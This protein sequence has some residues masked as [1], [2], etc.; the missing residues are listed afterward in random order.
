MDLV[1]GATP[2]NGNGIE[3]AILDTGI[4]LRHEVF[5]SKGERQ[6]EGHNFVSNDPPDSWY[7][8]PELHGTAVA[9]IAAGNQYSSRNGPCLGGIAPSAKLYICRIFSCRKTKREWKISALNHLID[10]K[11]NSKNR[12]DVVVMSFGKQ[13]KENEV[14]KKLKQLADLGVV[15]V[16]AGGNSGPRPDDAFFPSSNNH[17]I[18]VGALDR[19]GHKTN[20]SAT[21][22]R[23]YAPG[24]SIYVPSVVR[25]STTDVCP[26]NGTSFAAPVLGGFLALLLQSANNSKNT[27]VIEKCH[28]INFLNTLLRDHKL[29][30]DE[31]LWYA[32]EVLQ[33]LQ[34]DPSYI[35][36]L[37]K[38]QYGNEV[39]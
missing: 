30:R 21:H 2:L 38:D 35:V 25:N 12:I 33:S 17:V 26:V 8:K 18:S 24:E 5:R 23:V 36:K 11:R 15:L 14:E 39:Q 22:C 7:T 13:R 10:L 6:I 1:T 16:A 27:F 31:K 20:F 29:V 19:H 9:A 28:D 32:H 37:V 3:I 34:D 4:F